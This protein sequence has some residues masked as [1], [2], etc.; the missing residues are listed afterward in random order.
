VRELGE[1]LT[2]F[3]ELFEVAH[4]RKMTPEELGY[5]DVAQH[6]LDSKPDEEPVL[7]RPRPKPHE[8]PL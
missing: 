5:V 6:I 3:R 8:D 1:Q 2:R 7:T 4:N